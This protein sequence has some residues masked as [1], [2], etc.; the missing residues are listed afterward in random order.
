MRISAEKTDREGGNDAPV[1][2]EA[3]REGGSR[4]S[5][6]EIQQAWEGGSPV[7]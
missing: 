1:G 3:P 4:Q 5:S 7:L 6:A 2:E